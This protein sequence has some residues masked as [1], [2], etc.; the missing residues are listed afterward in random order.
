MPER[1]PVLTLYTS[2]E[3]A[4]A[5]AAKGEAAELHVLTAGER[6]VNA[7]GQMRAREFLGLLRLDNSEL[8]QEAAR[9]MEQ[10]ADERAR[11]LAWRIKRLAKRLADPPR[12]RPGRPPV[13]DFEEAMEFQRLREEGRTYEEAAGIL[14]DRAGVDDSTVKR[15]VRS[16]RLRSS[17]RWPCSTKV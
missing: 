4:A 5:E 1:E 8:L 16:T 14:A 13:Y 7:D 17:G 10:L 2:R 9:V 12:K 15:R 11:L 6:L 3:A